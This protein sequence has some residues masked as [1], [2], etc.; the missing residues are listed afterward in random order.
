MYIPQINVHVHNGCSTCGSSTPCG[1]S[2][3]GASIPA[4]TLPSAT[5]P[6]NDNSGACKDAVYAK[7]MFWDGIDIPEYGILLNPLSTGCFRR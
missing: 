5:L 4:Q 2:N 1:C 6:C 3:Q 7:C